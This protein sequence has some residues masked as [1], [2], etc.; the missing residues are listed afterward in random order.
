MSCMNLISRSSFERSEA[1]GFWGLAPI[2]KRMSVFAGDA[3]LALQG[4][5]PRRPIFLLPQ[6]AR[7]GYSS[8]YIKR[9]YLE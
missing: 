3:P 1:G 2:K 4:P 9:V 6:Y 7:R 8:F 5:L